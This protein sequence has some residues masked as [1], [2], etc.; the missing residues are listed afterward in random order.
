LTKLLHL[1]YKKGIH[2]PSLD[3]LRGVAV[4]LVFIFH[5]MSYVQIFRLGWIGVD[6]FF[7][8]SGFL[9]TGILYDS[10]NQAGYYKNFIVRRALRIFPLYF[11]F[12]LLILWILPTLFPALFTGMTY[13]QHHQAW[14]W[15]YISNWLPRGTADN[16]ST[17][18]NHLWSLSIEEQFYVCWPF[19]VVFFQGK[20]LIKICLFLIFCA[21]VIRYT[22]S[23]LLGNLKVFEYT[24]TLARIDSLL[25]GA[26]ISILYRLNPVI[27]I[28]SAWPIL[29]LSSFLLL[30]IISREKTLDFARL[31]DTFTLWDLFFG[32]VLIFSISQKNN[33]L[34]SILNLK[35][36][37][38]FG[39]YSYGLYIYHLPVYIIIVDSFIGFRKLNF[40][41]LP[42]VATVVC[43][44]IT[45][46]IAL[47]SYYLIEK[48]FLRLKKYFEPKKISA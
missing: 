39:K 44:F 43:L 46:G 47:L 21:I 16:T 48:P 11:F 5:T 3:G 18:L 2:Y 19:F 27:L 13:Y 22:G 6:L 17:M 7:V 1:E 37:K 26:L 4:I 12:I 36:F 9:I 42:L 15:F 24:S 28:K 31:I 38:F 32:A 41:Y 34:K 25:I 10:K 23:P 20:T 14:Y 40:R 35:F 29:I 45:I 30:L 33:W 8:L